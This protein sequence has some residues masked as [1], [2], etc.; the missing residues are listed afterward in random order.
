MK[1]VIVYPKVLRMASRKSFLLLLDSRGRTHYLVS[2]T[3]FLT[4]KIN[5][6]RIVLNMLFYSLESWALKCS[7][8]VK[9]IF[10]IES[11]KCCF[12]TRKYGA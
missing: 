8:L 9:K 1:V 5:F 12:I 3:S 10:K 4:S 2:Q 6:L 11:N 7:V